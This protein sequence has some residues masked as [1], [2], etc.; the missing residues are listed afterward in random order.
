MPVC[1]PITLGC[2]DIGGVR[3]LWRLEIPKMDRFAT[4][5][6]LSLP[7]VV[8]PKYAGKAAFVIRP[9]ATIF[10]VICVDNRPEIYKSVVSLVSIQVVNVVFRPLTRNV[11]PRDTVCVVAS[12]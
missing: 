4:N 1:K 9:N 10:A 5:S 8:L 12:A 7:L 3:G 11:K 2:L 6:D